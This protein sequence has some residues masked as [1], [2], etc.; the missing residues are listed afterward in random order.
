MAATVAAERE[1][2]AT[3]VEEM[4]EVGKVEEARAP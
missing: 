3:A 2:V 1:V 4:E